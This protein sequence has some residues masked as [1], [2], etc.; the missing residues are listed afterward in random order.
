MPWP[1]LGMALGPSDRNV[2]MGPCLISFIFLLLLR[3]F[4]K[5]NPYID[6]PENIS[7]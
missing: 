7:R 5:L 2:H 1:T 4:K 3:A 6:F